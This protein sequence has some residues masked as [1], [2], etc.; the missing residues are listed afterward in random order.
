MLSN[1]SFALSVVVACIS[2]SGCAPI[3]EHQA[4][5]QF[6]AAKVACKTRYPDAV[7]NMVNQVACINDAANRDLLSVEAY[8]DLL[9]LQ[10]AYDAKIAHEVDARQMSLVD[11]KLKEAAF[12]ANVEN[13]AEARRAGTEAASAQARA[14]WAA[15]MAAEGSLLQATQPQPPI[16]V[17][18]RPP[19]P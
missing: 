12:L 6:K 4:L 18:P 17:A 7:G 3:R 10:E 19:Y 15:V 14:S 8:P 1:R 9:N 13:V 16:Y 2:L 5:D 11:G